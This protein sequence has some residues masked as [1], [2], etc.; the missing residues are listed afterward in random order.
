MT[1]AITRLRGRGV[2]RTKAAPVAPPAEEWFSGWHVTKAQ[3]RTVA[4]GGL[5]PE[6]VILARQDLEFLDLP[7]GEAHQRLVA[8]QR[9]RKRR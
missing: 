1:H 7:P 4:A 6:W 5:P 8:R 9:A 2:A 3:L